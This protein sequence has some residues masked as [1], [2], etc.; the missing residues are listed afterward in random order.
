MS[1]S[2]IKADIFF[3]V[4]TIGL[5]LLTLLLVV[6]LVYIVSILRTI[7]R[8]SK[9]AQAGTETIVAGIQEAKATVSKD[10]FVPETLFSIFRKLYTKQAKRKK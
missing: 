8:I 3:F 10:G 6:G 9:T 4:A 7:R 1:D 2:L 5:A